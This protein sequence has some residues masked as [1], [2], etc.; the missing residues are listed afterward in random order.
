MKTYAFVFTVALLLSANLYA[1]KINITGRNL[2]LEKIFRE[3][4]K[5]TDYSFL[6]GKETLK[7]SKPVNLNLKN[8]S[9]A[10]VLDQCLTDQQLTWE[11]KNKVIVVTPVPTSAP[12]QP[13]TMQAVPSDPD[14]IMWGRVID[15]H[16]IPVIGASVRASIGADRIQMS[17]T[18]EKG[19]FILSE[20]DMPSVQLQ[21]TSVNI[22]P[23][24]GELKKQPQPQVIHVKSKVYQLTDVKVVLNTGYQKLDKERATGSFGKPDMAIVSKRTGTMDIMS[25]LDGLIP[26]LTLS[27]GTDQPTTANPNGNGVSTRKSVIRGKGTLFL[28]TDPLYV[29]NGTIVTDFS[30]LNPDDVESIT[31]LKDAAAAAIYG[32]RA[33][34][35]VVVVT[36]K[37]GKNNQRLTVNYN[38][39]FNYQGK[40]D[41]SYIPVLTSQ[42]FI[43]VAKE[44]FNPQLYPWNS[45]YDQTIAPHDQLLYDHYRGLISDAQ[46][47]KGMDSLGN[48]NNR[49]QILDLLVRPAM[50]SNHTISV[51]GGNNMYSFYGSLA[52]TLSQD[53]TPGN[54]NNS[55]K[56][57][58]T[59]NIQPS[60]NIRISV[61]ASLINNVSSGRNAIEA[62]PSALPYLLLRDAS[63][64]NI[65]ADFMLGWS[66][67]LRLDYQNRSK[68]NMGY[69]PLDEV[70]YTSYN[71]NNIFINLTG[72]ASVKIWKGLSFEGTYGY[73][74]S[75]GISKYFTD[76]REYRQRRQLLSFTIA[77][78]VNST[79]QYLVP[80]TGGTFTS[81]NNDQRNWTV[82]NQLIYS[83]TPRQGKDHLLLQVGQEA[84]EQFNFT[85]SNTYMGY[86]EKMGT[87]GLV[88]YASLSNGATG[89]V[90]GYGYLPQPYYINQTLSRFTSRF[91]LAS[92]TFND[93]YSLD[94]SWRQDKSNLF[95]SDVSSQN[96]PVWSIGAKWQLG[97]ENFFKSLSWIDNLGIRAT[98]GIT[99]NSPYVGAASVQDI[100]RAYP[101]SQSGGVGGDALSINSTA[102]TKLSWETTHTIN[103]GIDYGLLKGRI[104]G[105]IDIYSK[106]TTNMLGNIPLNPFTGSYSATGNLGKYSNKGIELSIS[107]QNIKSTDFNWSSTIIFSYNHNKLLSFQ[108][109]SGYSNTGDYKIN[110]F[111]YVG[112]PAGP[113]FAYN[114]AGLDNVGDPQIRL[115]D[116]TV[117]KDP[118]YK[119]TPDDIKYMGTTVPVF[120]GGITNTFSYKAVSLSVNMIYNLGNVMRRDVDRTY[121]AR[122]SSMG[123]NFA[124]G[125]LSAYFLDRWKKPGDEAFT[126][127]PVYLAD[128]AEDYRR[129]MN[130]Y[131]KADINVVSAAYIKIRDITLNYELPADWLKSL[132][133]KQFSIY[134]Q[135]TNFLVWKANHL[136]VDPEYQDL[137]QGY[138]SVPP[139]LHSYSL[140]VNVTL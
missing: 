61:N 86:D 66:D 25:R 57:N 111:Y 50:S 108:P 8:A 13:A 134:G 131:Y 28:D 21:I 139:Y 18:D 64:K 113:V 128:P 125:N 96:K 127:A 6:V 56:I 37:S 122:L 91:A 14:N 45:Q 138:M 98:Y 109:L 12:A 90:T 51:S 30:T 120:N 71:R 23:W 92:Y 104:N 43:S 105:G 48:I 81:G 85:T 39:F 27:V 10:Q 103:I 33:A 41:F 132:N 87:Y 112:Y 123:A 15:E 124:A 137:R 135:A 24:T 121:A 65:P 93:K 70:N 97:K 126:N 130:Y 59:Q 38:G 67:S 35:G 3:V 58:L 62:G 55:Y 47:N 26:G 49:Q 129:N 106:T 5:Q 44:L 34:N 1:Q 119:T 107:S 117:T 89:T 79:P 20:V 78:T 118:S 114:Y 76:N 53:N 72:N 7:K 88:D 17:F 94:G 54:K 84:Q 69:V 36:T 140:G 83:A 75:P 22:E 99:G 74:K 11:I 2:S 80:I 42:Q 4:E 31:V 60:R 100:L 32:A 9:L 102:N 52:Y 136:G 115:G 95:G 101:Q 46:F 68:I 82:R 40:P 116:K 63:G 77:P 19:D 73:V 110:S 133:I 29:I 16:N